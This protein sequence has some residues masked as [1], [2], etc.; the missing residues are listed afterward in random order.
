MT[1]TVHPSGRRAA[2][3]WVG[4]TGSFLVVAAAAAFVAVKW[5][6]I[7]D[8][9]KLAMVAGLTVACLVG[10]R[11]LRP[12]LP[13]MG[14]VLFHLGAFLVPVDVA[15]VCVRLHAGWRETLLAEGAVCV[16]A[17]GG[18]DRKSVV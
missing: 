8:L 1:A 18:L 14:D 12:A 10:G 16:A 7:P 11:A 2:A 4:A 6:E 5:N 13:A 3:T 17:F 15:A 9:G